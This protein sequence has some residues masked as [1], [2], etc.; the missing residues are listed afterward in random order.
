MHA[1]IY[2]K[3]TQTPFK[4][5]RT[6]D[7]MLAWLEA[8]AR[9]T[10]ARVKSLTQLRTLREEHEVVVLGRFAKQPSQAREEKEFVKCSKLVDN[11]KFAI[12][13]DSNEDADEDLRSEIEKNF[14]QNTEKKQNANIILFSSF[15]KSFSSS[16]L[17]YEGD[18]DFIDIKKFI[19]ANQ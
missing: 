17:V 11:V 10:V 16:S 9:V 13:I 5:G 15:S 6:Q 8:K 19:N 18:F 12:V 4:G 14:E 7:S 2:L 3:G 1:N